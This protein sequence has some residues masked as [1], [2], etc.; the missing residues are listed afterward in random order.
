MN[1][2]P[3][4]VRARELAVAAGELPEADAARVLA[5][6]GTGGAEIVTPPRTGL[7]MMTSRDPFD[8]TFCVGEVLVTEAAVSAG[9][10]RGWGVAIGDAPQRAL[11]GAV[12]D[13]LG[14]TGDL[15]GLAQAAALIAPAAERLAAERRQEAALVARTKVRFDLMPGK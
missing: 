11:L 4:A 5:A 7:A 15:A 10:T 14:R 6:L 13:L 1:P 12:L 9:E 8:T 3:A 2:N